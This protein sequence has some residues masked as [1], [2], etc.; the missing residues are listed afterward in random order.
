MHD[1]VST[2]IL[3]ILYPYTR[4]ASIEQAS[5]KDA[6][7]RENIRRLKIIGTIGSL[8][9]VMILTIYVQADGI[10]Q[11]LSL[12]S[13]TRELWILASIAYIIGVG[14]T[15]PDKPVKK[16]QFGVFFF[17]ATLSLLFSAI[18]TAMST[19]E[20]G[21]TFLYI[22]NILLT[23]TFL[24]F[25][26]A[27]LFIV[28]APSILLLLHV[29]KHFD[30]SILRINA[31]WINIVAISL[32]AFAI[33]HTALVGRLSHLHSKKVIEEQNEALKQLA[34]LDGL[35]GI[36]NRRKIDMMLT[37]E[38]RLAVGADIPIT[39]MMIDIDYFKNYNDTYGHQVGDD[40]L[41][42]IAKIIQSHVRR[43]S[44][45]VGRYGGEEFLIMMTGMD[46]Q[47]SERM[48]TTI[49]TAISNLEI[50]HSASP[51]QHVTVSIGVVSRRLNE[52]DLIGDLIN[53][54]DL[55]MYEA[56]ELGRNRVVIR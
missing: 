12:E 40:C 11:L 16:V 30:Y 29:L 1:T 5:L 8:I 38:A 37:S 48:A 10:S 4:Y 23:A 54:A 41:K 18:I 19:P 3:S 34:E 56:K 7:W 36:G 9:N 46:V 42:R 2:K 50:P 31:N 52:H 53:E 32:F 22:I 45:L 39:V 27:E 47:E 14:R 35:T 33:A 44:D 25:S 51:F 15:T 20:Q 28:V 21:H 6:I 55:A 13:I 17:A 43:Q 49:L 24:H 26:L